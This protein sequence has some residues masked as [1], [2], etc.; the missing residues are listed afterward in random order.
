MEIFMCSIRYFALSEGQKNVN[1]YD[2]ALYLANND[3]M[4]PVAAYTI[5]S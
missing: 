3:K 4:P 2:A 5:F 1:I